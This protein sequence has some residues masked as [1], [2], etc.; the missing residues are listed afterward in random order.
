MMAADRVASPL[1][2]VALNTL[3]E[4]T[5]VVPPEI[6]PETTRL[7]ET[8]AAERVRRPLMVAVFNTLSDDIVVVPPEIVPETTRLFCI[9]TADTD[10]SPD[11]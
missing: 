3:S 1:M 11:E 4:E 6:V 9:L 7:L 5:V 2:V 8:V 10:S